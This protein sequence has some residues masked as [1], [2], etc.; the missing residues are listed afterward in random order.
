MERINTYKDH[1]L[2]VTVR[3]EGL[4]IRKKPAWIYDSDLVELYE[5]RAR[6]II[7][8]ETIP[9][10]AAEF[11]MRYFWQ[12]KIKFSIV[13]PEVDATSTQPS[14]SLDAPQHLRIKAKLQLLLLNLIR[15]LFSQPA[16]MPSW[17][18]CH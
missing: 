14:P 11:H 7:T 12:D 16:E 15:T 6:A 1:R 4:V 9:Q 18:S 2:E 10:L 3:D 17:I 5:E 13:Y 8:R